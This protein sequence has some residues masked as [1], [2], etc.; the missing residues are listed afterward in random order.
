MLSVLT[1]T[2]KQLVLLLCTIEA[3]L[4]LGRQLKHQDQVHILKTIALVRKMD[5]KFYQ[6]ALL[7]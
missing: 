6:R 5:L 4:I 1:T 2:L 3:H 7:A